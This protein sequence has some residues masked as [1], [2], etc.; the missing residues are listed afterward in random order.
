MRRAISAAVLV[1]VGVA[2][3]SGGGS[4]APAAPPSVSPCATHVVFELGTLISPSPN[5]TNVPTS[6][7]SLTV[8]SPVQNPT[9]PLAGLHVML[10]VN[11]TST[12]ITGGAFTAASGTTYTA[13]VP[14]LA[15]HTTYLV[16]A[17]TTSTAPNCPSPVYYQ[18]G[19]FT[20]Q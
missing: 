16:F 2:G 8:D 3:C 1:L 13:S 17:A 10:G 15:P 5:A 19:S 18:F 20:T 4:S 6:V 12:E 9:A 7:G 11:G 14:P